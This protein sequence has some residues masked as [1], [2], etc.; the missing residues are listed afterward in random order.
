MPRRPVH[1]SN[2][3]CTLGPAQGTS[4]FLPKKAAPA[5]LRA[6]ALVETVVSKLGPG[7]AAVVD[8]GHEAVAGAVARE[9]E[10]LTIG[11]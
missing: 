7:G 5:A 4:G 3:L 11:E 6:G 1:L 2:L 8:C 9:W 10:G